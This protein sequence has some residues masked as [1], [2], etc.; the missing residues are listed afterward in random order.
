MGT[1]WSDALCRFVDAA[2]RVEAARIAD[3]GKALGNDLNEKRLVVA[4][5]NISGGMGGE[6][7]LTAAL[8]RQEAE[9]DHFALLVIKPR[10]GVIIA[11]AVV[12]KPVVDMTA[13]FRAGL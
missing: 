10:A 6:L 13:L 8:R 7:R 1:A 12:G 2:Q 5:G 9:R 11:E 3:I 4:D